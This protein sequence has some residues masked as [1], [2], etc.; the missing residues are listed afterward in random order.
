MKNFKKAKADFRSFLKAINDERN[1]FSHQIFPPE[2][3]ELN[4]DAN[5]RLKRKIKTA[6]KVKAKINSNI[7]KPPARK[8][9]GPQ[10]VFHLFDNKHS[11][12]PKE[13]SIEN[14]VEEI[15]WQIKDKPYVNG[16]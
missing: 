15:L 4:N 2:F 12:N 14:L 1:S 13:I 7:R 9:Q 6:L 3:D 11:K 8:S 10:F 16:G 5:F